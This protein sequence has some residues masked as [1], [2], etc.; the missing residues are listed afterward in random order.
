MRLQVFDQNLRDADHAGAS[1]RLWGLG[2]F[3]AEVI[4]LADGNRG[5]VQIHIGP[6]ESCGLAAPEAG[7]QQQHRGPLGPM[8]R[9]TDPLLLFLG[10]RL[11]GLCRGPGGAGD[12]CDG[13]V[14]HDLRNGQ[15]IHS[16]GTGTQIGQREVGE[17]RLAVV[18]VGQVVQDLL[19]VGSFQL[20]G[21]H[22]LQLAPV[23]AIVGVPVQALLPDA[24]GFF[25]RDQVVVQ[26][27]ERRFALLRVQPLA[28]R[29][30]VFGGGRLG[31]PLRRTI[32]RL[33]PLG[34]IGVL[35][36]VDPIPVAAIGILFVTC[37]KNFNSFRSGLSRCARIALSDHP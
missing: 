8:G 15:I 35:A 6:G 34:P 2:L 7:V 26:L 32:E 10:D 17:G 27:A 22:V 23:V 36:D 13:V 1:G 12:L 31:F 16:L 18:P 4:A 37:H 9:F 30:A 33:E 21:G 14:E 3:A 11:A 28:E 29:S 20:P 24:L 25:D 5:V 19:E